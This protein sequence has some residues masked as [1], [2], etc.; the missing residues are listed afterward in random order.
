[1]NLRSLAIG[2]FWVVSFA[3]T[4]G[5]ESK[6]TADY[7]KLGLVPVSGRVT[8]DGQPLAK[9]VV[10]FDDAEDGTFSFGHTDSGGYY[11]L[12][13]DSDRMG[14]K[15]GRKIVRISTTRKIL[16]LNSSEEG[17]ESGLGE[18]VAKPEPTKELVPDKYYKKSEL[19]AEVSASNK[20]FNFELKSAAA[21]G[22]GS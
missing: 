22:D 13:L 19:S 16:G 8:L 3:I 17:G 20:T 18:Q 5:C 10:T 1:M 2:C 14:V 11:K 6:P 7:G 9:A 15:P 4:S 12:R 21:S